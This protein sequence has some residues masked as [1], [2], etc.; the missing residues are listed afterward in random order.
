MESSSTLSF[1]NLG[2][3]STAEYRGQG[4]GLGLICASILELKQRGMRGCFVDWV[5]LKGTYQELGMLI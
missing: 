1:A 3:S 4:V 5:D 2:F